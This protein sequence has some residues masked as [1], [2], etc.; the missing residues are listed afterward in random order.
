MQIRVI[1]RLS[2]VKPT[3]SVQKIGSVLK[4]IP[5]RVGHHRE[6]IEVS[7]GRLALRCDRCGWE[8]P[9]WNLDPPDGVKPTSARSDYQLR[10]DQA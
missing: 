10:S 9:G 8:S 3:D 7:K 5:C 6:K 4:Q 2:P 1:I